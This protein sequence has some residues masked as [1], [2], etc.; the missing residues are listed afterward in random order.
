MDHRKVRS[1]L[2]QP[3][4]KSVTEV[5]SFH[6]L[7]T[8]YRCFIKDFGKIA[9]PFTDYLKKGQFY[10]GQEQQASFDL[11]KSKLTSASVLALPNFDKFFEVKIDASKVRIGVVLM[12]RGRFVEYFSEKLCKA[13]QN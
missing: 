9:T 8:F 6:D 1:I 12:Q 13:R 5:R 2:D 4:P 10:W 11:L 3:L 7:A